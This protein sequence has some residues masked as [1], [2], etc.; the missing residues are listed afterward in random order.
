ML[1]FYRR[2]ARKLDPYRKWFVVAAV[3]ALALIVGFPDAAFWPGI[4]QTILSL[5]FFWSVG[6]YMIIWGFK[7]GQDESSELEWSGFIPSRRAVQ[8]L[9]AFVIPWWFLFPVVVEVLYYLW[10]E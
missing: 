3:V 4:F 10:R 2:I 6:F 5:L 1:R 7:P 9:M 8:W